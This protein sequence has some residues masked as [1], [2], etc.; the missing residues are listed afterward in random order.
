MLCLEQKRHETYRIQKG[1]MAGK[2]N[3]INTIEYEPL[4]A[5]KG[6]DCQVGEK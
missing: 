5:A 6:Q 2:S 3:C 1:K 4:N